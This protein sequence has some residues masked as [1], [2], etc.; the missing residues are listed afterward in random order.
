MLRIKMRT[1]VIMKHLFLNTKKEIDTE[2]LT[3][4]ST[5]LNKEK[6]N[7]KSISNNEAIKLDQLKS[8]TFSIAEQMGKLNK[9]DDIDKNVIKNNTDCHFDAL[10]LQKCWKTIIDDFKSKQKNNI[11]IILSSNNPTIKNDNEIN[12]FVN[13]LSQIELIEDEKYTILNY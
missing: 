3:Q 10:D 12:I 9:E 1:M 2:K 11:A 5:Y 7:I 4:Q 8:K 13:N 6:E